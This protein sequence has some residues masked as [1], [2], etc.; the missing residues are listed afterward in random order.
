MNKTKLLLFLTTV[1]L[2][3]ALAI[4]AT[5]QAK[6]PIPPKVPQPAA[7]PS[8]GPA[9]S[10]QKVPI[11]PLRQFKPQEP[12]R[13]EL[14]NGMGIFLQDA[15]ELP[16]FH[17]I[18]RIRGGAREERADKV[19]VLDLYADVWRTGSTRDKTGDQPD[20]FLEAH[21]AP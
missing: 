1:L 18:I 4:N 19:G 13:V 16:L 12:R 11:P 20:D 17:G 5:A 7:T 8:A 21:A 2:M 3:N 15:H 9:T 10:W 6:K 14:P